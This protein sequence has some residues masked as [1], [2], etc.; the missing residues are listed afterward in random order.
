MSPAS[1]KLYERIQESVG[2]IQAR[3]SLRPEVGIVLGSGMGALAERATDS[4]T[5]PYSEIPN[6]HGTSIEGYSGQMTIGKIQ[7][8]AAVFLKG[9]FHRYEGYGMDEVV[10]PTRVIS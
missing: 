2:A 1:S 3:T 4:V 9:R 8:V 7:G 5:I 10:F 6:F